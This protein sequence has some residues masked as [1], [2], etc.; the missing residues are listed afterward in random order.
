MKYALKKFNISEEAAGDLSRLIGPPL[1]MSF[2]E[3]FH[4]DKENAKRAVAYYR[5][6]YTV[7]GIYE[8]K[9]YDDMETLLQ[10]L[11]RRGLH[12]FTASSKPE[13]F[14][15]IVLQHFRIDT[16]FDGIVGSNMDGTRSAK[17][18][19]IKYVLEA[20]H[21]KKAETIMVGDTKYDMAGAKKNGIDSLAVTYGYGTV[22]ELKETEPTYICNT[23]M[24]I[25]ELL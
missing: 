21:L 8:N 25:L 2:R 7:K 3:F 6:Y 11:R 18:D 5:E 16:Y 20:Y 22:E 10:T 14:A 17:E 19:V 13:Q 15:K 24:E 1:E 9:L 4:L 23:L 12:C